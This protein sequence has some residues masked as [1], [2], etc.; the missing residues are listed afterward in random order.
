VRFS[1]AEAMLRAVSELNRWELHGIPLTVDVS[2]DTAK[3]LA[4]GKRLTFAS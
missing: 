1:T 2:K 3:R 4:K